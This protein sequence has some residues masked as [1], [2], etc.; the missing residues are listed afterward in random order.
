MPARLSHFG[1]VTA[2]SSGHFTAK[3]R[4][5]QLLSPRLLSAR[6]SPSPRERIPDEI[7]NSR[8]QKSSKVEEFK[9][10]RTGPTRF[11]ALPLLGLHFPSSFFRFLMSS[12]VS[13]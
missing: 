8:K 4:P 9:G 5:Q 11:G 2:L 12:S 3:P 13:S 7:K 6:M 1:P 10:K